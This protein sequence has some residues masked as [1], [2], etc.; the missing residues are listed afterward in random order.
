MA[1]PYCYAA[2]GGRV[3]PRDA[4]YRFDTTQYHWIR[5][6]GQRAAD[7]EGVRGLRSEPRL[8]KRDLNWHRSGD[9]ERAAPVATPISGGICEAI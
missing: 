2:D 3:V 5:A 7:A 4:E 9:A 1:H 6:N 8:L